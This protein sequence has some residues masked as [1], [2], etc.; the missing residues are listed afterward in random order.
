[1][2]Y[3]F[4]NK[5]VKCLTINNTFLILNI[6]EVVVLIRKMIKGQILLGRRVVCYLI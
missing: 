6:G 4:N 1:M 3:K 2:L 5:S